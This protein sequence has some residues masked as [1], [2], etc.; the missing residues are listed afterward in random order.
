MLRI[1]GASIITIGSMHKNGFDSNG[2]VPQQVTVP[3]GSAKVPVET[4]NSSLFK[5]SLESMFN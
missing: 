4:T 1:R 3:L 2:Q 5:E